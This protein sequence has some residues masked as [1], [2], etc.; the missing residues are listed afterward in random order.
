MIEHDKSSGGSETLDGVEALVQ[1]VEAR[2]GE[3]DRLATIL[4]AHV[5]QTGTADGKL[6]CVRGMI[7]NARGFDVPRL[8]TIIREYQRTHAF[9]L[10]EWEHDA[11]RAN[12]AEAERDSLRERV[13]QLEKLAYLGDHHFD[14]MTYKHCLEEEHKRVAKLEAENADL[15]LAHKTSFEHCEELTKKCI[16]L[17]TKLRRKTLDAIAARRQCDELRERL[18]KLETC[19]VCGAHLLPSGSPPHCA[20]TCT[21]DE[22]HEAEWESVRASFSK[23][24][25]QLELNAL[26][27]RNAKLEA[28]NALLESNLDNWKRQYASCQ[29]DLHL[30][31]DELRKQMH[32]AGVDVEGMDDVFQR[33]RETSKAV[34]RCYEFGMLRDALG[35]PRIVTPAWAINE[36]CDRLSKLEA[37]KQAVIDGMTRAIEAEGRTNKA[38]YEMQA[39]RDAMKAAVL[40]YWDCELRSDTSAFAARNKLRE[41][42]GLPPLGMKKGVIE[43]P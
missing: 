5:N 41:M 18:A 32:M 28:D 2:S 4:A 36:L 25:T 19:I 11:M 16:D 35:M 14:D 34:Y 29:A 37:G 30:T 39:E 15:V 20:D 21:V 7:E 17:E 31:N 6:D 33:I 42:V 3:F 1:A 22:E 38:F 8:T 43:W 13:T 27:S 26:R 23:P 12:A 9:A 24:E 10:R 40:E